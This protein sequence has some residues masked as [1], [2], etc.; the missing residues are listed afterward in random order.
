MKFYRL[1]MLCALALCACAPKDNP[2]VWTEE[3]VMPD[4]RIVTL[5]RVQHFDEGDYVGAHSFE[6]EHPT[7]KQ[8]I[9]WE[10]GAVVNLSLLTVFMWENKAHILT[11]PRFGIDNQNAGCPYPSVLLFR[12]D[13]SGWTQV[14]YAQSPLPEIRN[15]ATADPKS[16]REHIRAL[17]YKISANGIQLL[18]HPIHAY[19]NGVSF[20]K[21]PTQT[22]QCLQF[23]KVKFQ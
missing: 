22:F 14:P 16:S 1:L 15:N 13:G 5:K 18:T 6:F 20:S 11:S 9:K 3:V 7:T 21:R 23:Q 12:W 2:L 4:Q 19:E 8:T 10:S 17:N